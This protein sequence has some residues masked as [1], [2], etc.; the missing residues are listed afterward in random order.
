MDIKE[1]IDM[2]YLA[3]AFLIGVIIWSFWRMFTKRLPLDYFISLEEEEKRENGS[4]TD[5]TTLDKVDDTNEN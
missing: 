1:C 3:F 4:Q 2:G 5:A